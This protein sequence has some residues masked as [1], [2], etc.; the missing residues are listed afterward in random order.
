MKTL[1]KTLLVCAATLTSTMSGFGQGSLTPPGAPAPTMKTLDQVKAGTPI[2][3]APFTISSSGN[4]FLT[5]NLTVSGSDGIDVY[6]NGVTIDLNGF[7]IFGI[8]GCSGIN[9]GTANQDITI[10]NGHIRG[11]V[12]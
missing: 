8:G 1:L 4:Y 6:T 9:I 10:L 7:T 5:G 3:S 2:A 12:T 11:G